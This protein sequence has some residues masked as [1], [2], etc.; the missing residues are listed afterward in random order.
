MLAPRKKSYDKPRW[1]IKK[2]RHHFPN[3]GQYSQSYVFPVVKYGCEGCTLK[4]AEHQEL[5]LLIVVLE[6]TLQNPLDSKEIKPVNPKGNPSYSLEGMM[7][8]LKPNT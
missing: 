1:C 7:L 6:K 2:Q 5:M 3:R 4:K 8:K